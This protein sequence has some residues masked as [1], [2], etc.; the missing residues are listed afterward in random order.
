MST[1][2]IF[3][4]KSLSRSLLKGTVLNLGLQLANRNL[5]KKIVKG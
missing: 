2:Q 3:K 5:S 1:S 4:T